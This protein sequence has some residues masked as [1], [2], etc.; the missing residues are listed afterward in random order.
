MLSLVQEGHPELLRELL[1]PI[2]RRRDELQRQHNAL[3]A[4]R[5]LMPTPERTTTRG[6]V[7]AYERS[8]SRREAFP[9]AAS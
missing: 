5:A 7:A 3:A 6:A 9:A 2:D 8:Q 1:F 4:C